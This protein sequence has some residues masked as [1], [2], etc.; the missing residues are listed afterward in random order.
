MIVLVDTD[1][2]I[3]VVLDRAP[4][5][6]HAAALLDAL[7]RG[8]SRGW[9]AW[10]SISNFYYLVSAT[11]GRAATFTFL[12]ELTQFLDVAPTTRDHLRRALKFELKDFEDAM[13]VGAATACGADFI[14]TRNVRDF[15]KSPIPAVTPAQALARLA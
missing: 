3:D 7:E 10:H 6:D 12:D 15:R 9:L 5:A 8:P 2:L 1:V 4:F 11:Q 13:Q 14:A